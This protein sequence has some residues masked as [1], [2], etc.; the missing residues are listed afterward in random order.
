MKMVKFFGAVMALAVTVA[1]LSHGD[2]FA[3]GAAAKSAVHPGY[4]GDLAAL[5]S[6][7]LATGLEPLRAQHTELVRAAAAKAAEAK[8]GLPADVVTRIET[9]HRSMLTDI[10]TVAAA[11]TAEE[12][13]L[14]TNPTPPP[15]NAAADAAAAATRAAD[16]LSIGTRAGMVQTDIE[17]AVRDANVGVE[18]FRTRAFEVMASRS[19]SNETRSVRGGQE[20]TETRMRHLSDAL[21]VRIGGANALRNAEG[22]VQPLSEGARGFRDFSLV[23]MAAEVIGARSVRSAAQREDVLRRA[24]TT[25]S[26]FPI[27]FESSINRVLASRYV[28]QA[29]TY[30]RI[31]AQRQFRD[32][33]PH[34]QVR[35]GDF[36]TLQPVSQ[37]GEIK[38]GSF[39]ESK[40]TVAVAPYAVQFAISRRMLVDD[41][42]G[43]I[44]QMLGSYG[45]T[46]AMFEET[47]FYAM[48][49]ANAAGPLLKED[50]KRV[51][52]TDHG[53]LAGAGTVINT[54]ALSAGRAALREM[55]NQSGVSINVAARIILTGTAKETEAEMAVAAVT[56]TKASDVNPFSGK[57]EVIATPQMTGNA[58]ELYADPAMLPVFVWGLLDGYTAPRLRLDN[59]FGVQGVGVSLEHDFGCGAIDFRGA[60]R[61]P[62]A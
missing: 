1:V 7:V 10:Q 40:E 53:N 19:A 26:D 13:R 9:E 55:K 20:E 43:A 14:Q 16:I 42:I 22:Q 27:I 31:A 28:T 17:A 34:D 51:F 56:A 49:L 60:Y 24:F 3:A 47:T 50:N 29:P 15:A 2:A 36:P 59:P 18:A 54:A 39:G 23:D 45:T 12:R 6:L 35:V 5:A 38:F 52:H 32:F 61:N 11:I 58:W 25:T 46:V 62:G 37:A 21:T 30:R 48:K 44:D 41:N 8:D 4:A 33:R 57:L